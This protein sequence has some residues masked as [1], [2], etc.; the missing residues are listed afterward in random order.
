MW[1]QILKTQVSTE[2]NHSP[3]EP[4]FK[5]Q[6][7]HVEKSCLCTLRHSNSPKKRQFQLSRAQNLLFG[8]LLIPL[9]KF[10]STFTFWVTSCKFFL[11]FHQPSAVNDVEF[12]HTKA[13]LYLSRRTLEPFLQ[14]RRLFTSNIETYWDV[15]GILIMIYHDISP[16]INRPKMWLNQPKVAVIPR[17]LLVKPPGFTAYTPNS[18][19]V[20]QP[21]L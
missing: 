17:V 4:R 15:T 2:K 5:Q 21:F 6:A 3:V 7:K 14:N 19:N 8:W 16:M 20:L 13:A 11:I 9:E 12:Y 1:F 18:P 10:R